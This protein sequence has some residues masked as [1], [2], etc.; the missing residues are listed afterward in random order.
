[1]TNEGAHDMVTQKNGRCKE[2]NRTEQNRQ[3]PDTSDPINWFIQDMHHACT[4]TYKQTNEEPNQT[5]QKSSKK[6]ISEQQQQ[7]SLTLSLTHGRHSQYKRRRS[8]P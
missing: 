8:S 3:T 5:N 4:H 2:T 6:T 7:L 1:M